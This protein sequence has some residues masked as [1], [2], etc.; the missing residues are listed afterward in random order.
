MVSTLLQLVNYVQ[1]HTLLN[2]AMEIANGKIGII[3]A[4][5]SLTLFQLGLDNFYHRNCIS[6]DTA[7][8]VGIGLT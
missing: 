2:G 1:V 4:I 8:L 5:V 6:R 3:I 7:Y